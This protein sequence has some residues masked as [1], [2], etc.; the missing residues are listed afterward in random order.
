V[1]EFIES[2]KATLGAIMSRIPIFIEVPDA[3]KEAN[4]CGKVVESLV[5]Q[6]IEPVGF[7]TYVAE[8]SEIL[9]TLKEIELE[10]A[11]FIV[12]TYKAKDIIT[13]LDP[14]IGEVPA[15]FLRRAL[16]A[17]Q[18][19]LMDHLAPGE[20][21]SRVQSTMTTLKHLTPRLTSIWTYGTKN[22]DQVATRILRCTQKFIVDGNFRH[23]EIENQSSGGVR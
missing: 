20:S 9:K 1:S 23:Y 4:I 18:S 7:A 6:K 21:V 19:G 12:N 3:T 15:V 16:Y 8:L 14:M 22:A 11:I 10:P 13:Q 2:Q 5:A 17:G